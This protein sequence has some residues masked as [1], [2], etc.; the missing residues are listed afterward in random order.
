MFLM[1]HAC[2]SAA[3]QWHA[4]GDECNSTQCH[5]TYKLLYHDILLCHE[6]YNYKITCKHQC[7]NQSSL[8]R[9][10]AWSCACGNLQDGCINVVPRCFAVVKLI[11]FAYQ[12]GSISWHGLHGCKHMWYSMVQSVN[13]RAHA[14]FASHAQ[15]VAGTAFRLSRLR[16][17]QKPQELWI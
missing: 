5:E 4:R 6:T 16:T 1:V 17:D 7:S 15:M 13:N 9:D 2:A 11:I 10:I 8:T 14:K 3:L 12:L